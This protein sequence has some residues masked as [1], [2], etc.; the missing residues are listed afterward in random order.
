MLGELIS[1]RRRQLGITQAKISSLLGYSNGQFISNIERGSSDMPKHQLKKMCRILLLDQH[2]VY[3][4]M[5]S[6]Y[7]KVVA[8][9][10]GLK[11]KE[12]NNGTN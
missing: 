8:K 9:S 12:I 4:V 6:E 5:M 1:K 3:D 10:L 7:A 2:L 11:Q